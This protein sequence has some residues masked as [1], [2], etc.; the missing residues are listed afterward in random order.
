MRT[1]GGTSKDRGG[2]GGLQFGVGRG[3]L[4]PEPRPADSALIT[5]GHLIG[6]TNHPEIPAKASQSRAKV[7]PPFPSQ[8]HSCWFSWEVHQEGNTDVMRRE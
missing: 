1:E 4:G 2:T 5:L 3:A 7:R 8:S 6:W